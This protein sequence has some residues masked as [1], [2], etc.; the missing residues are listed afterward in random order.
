LKL[1]TKDELQN[2][3]AEPEMMGAHYLL[4]LD[5]DFTVAIQENPM[6]MKNKCPSCYGILAETWKILTDKYNKTLEVKN[7]L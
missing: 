6:K 2:L 5:S 4:E 3:D 7:L 1:F